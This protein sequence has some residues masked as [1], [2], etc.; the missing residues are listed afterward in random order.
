MLKSLKQKMISMICLL[1]LL[2]LASVS[3]VSYNSA[4]GLLEKSID[5]EA[6][7]NAENL[8]MEINE[9]IDTK[10]AKIEAV[11]KLFTG[12]KEED[13]KLVQKAQES[14][15]EFETFLFSHVK[16]ANGVFAVLDPSWSRSSSFPTWGDVTLEI[17]GTKGT[18]SID[19]FSQKNDLY[20]DAAQKANWSYWG[21]DMDTELINSFVDSIVQGKPVSVS[22]E[23]GYLSARVGL[24]AY[25]SARI[26]QPVQLK[27][28]G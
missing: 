24:A 13:L 14:N 2:S 3:I 21:D 7:L 17:I 15:K 9:F 26:G 12:N 18:L 1:L 20:S 28:Q 22:G 19:A 5:E 6:R 27:P 8:A 23:D 25:E 16:F 11:G 10:I 4:S